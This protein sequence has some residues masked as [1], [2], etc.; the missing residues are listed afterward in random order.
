MPFT[1]SCWRGSFPCLYFDKVNVFT[2]LCSLVLGFWLCLFSCLVIILPN[3][4]SQGNL[5][6]R[7]RSKVADYLPLD[8][9][10]FRSWFIHSHSS[11]QTSIKLLGGEFITLL[12]NLFHF[13]IYRPPFLRWHPPWRLVTRAAAP[14]WVELGISW[15]LL[16]KCTQDPSP[17]ANPPSTSANSRIEQL[18]SV[19]HSEGCL[20]WRS[21][22]PWGQVRFLIW[23]LRSRN[24]Y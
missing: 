13:E 9:R 8:L 2:A 15:C 18:L 5:R 1:L 16:P 20:T 12:P 6:R 3:I 22:S 19:A 7:L 11:K 4:L 17:P 23:F 21:L 24:L 10:D 14:A